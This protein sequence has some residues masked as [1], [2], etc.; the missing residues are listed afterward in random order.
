M[1]LC[2]CCCCR[3]SDSSCS[4]MT[5]FGEVLCTCLHPEQATDT[6][7]RQ[8]SSRHCCSVAASSVGE[9]THVAVVVVVRVLAVSVGVRQGAIVAM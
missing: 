6:D 9:R 2:T 8:K 5:P 1:D 7:F 3:G 4:P